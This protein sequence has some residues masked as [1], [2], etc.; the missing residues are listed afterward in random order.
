MP[1]NKS[2]NDGWLW[3]PSLNYKPGSS[4]AVGNIIADPFNPDNVLCS[5]DLSDLPP[6]VESTQE[7]SRCGHQVT[8]NISLSGQLNRL[9][10][11]KLEEVFTY[12]NS[13][14]VVKGIVSN[15]FHKY[16]SGNELADQL[17]DQ[18]KVR[19][20]MKL[21]STF[22]K[23]VYLITGVKF[24][25]TVDVDFVHSAWSYGKRRVSRIPLNECKGDKFARFPHTG[26][27]HGEGIVISYAVVKVVPTGWV[28]KDLRVESFPE[29]GRAFIDEAANNWVS[30]L[31]SSLDLPGWEMNEDEKISDD[32]DEEYY[33]E[34]SEDDEEENEE[35]DESTHPEMPPIEDLRI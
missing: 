33:V 15:C 13:T 8:H 28:E 16:P 17:K 26:V 5:L 7:E 19:E 1:Q 27:F 10:K 34:E 2:F 23:P 21:D 14:I 30:F 3:A 35:E 20:A 22:S 32:E 24:V 29:E 31:E 11:G 25:Q 6:S 12:L 4:I 18:A 9:F